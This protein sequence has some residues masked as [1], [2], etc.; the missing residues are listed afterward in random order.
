M[1]KILIILLFSFGSLFSKDVIY[2]NG[3]N[4]DTIPIKATNGIDTIK[5]FL[6]YNIQN[7]EYWISLQDVNYEYTDNAIIGFFNFAGNEPFPAVATK[8]DKS[9]MFIISIKHLS[10]FLEKLISIEFNTKT[11]NIKYRILESD[12]RFLF[13]LVNLA[14]YKR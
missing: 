2:S 13:R 11:D 7:T 12:N 8:T 6:A 4:V 5:I 14:G 1:R 3:F 10:K 9:I